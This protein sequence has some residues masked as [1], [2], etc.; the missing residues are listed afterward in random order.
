METYKDIQRFVL[1]VEKLKHKHDI[2]TM[3]VFGADMQFIYIYFFF[4]NFFFL[5]THTPVQLV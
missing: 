3:Q 4:Y 5:H 2:T 1:Q